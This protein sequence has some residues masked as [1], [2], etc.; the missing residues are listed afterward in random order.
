MKKF[1]I[2]NLKDY[3]IISAKD[4]E[5]YLNEAEVRL[6][7]TED[8]VTFVFPNNHAPT[9]VHRII[10]AIEEILDEWVEPFRD[11]VRNRVY[12]LGEDETITW[13]NNI[14]NFVDDVFTN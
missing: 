13:D 7:T 10:D 3:A 9:A 2:L 1:R 6:D 12:T 14:G 11:G 4:F 5:N 8:S